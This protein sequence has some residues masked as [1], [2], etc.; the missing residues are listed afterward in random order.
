MCLAVLMVQLDT[1]V[2]NL[3]LRPIQINLHTGVTT[4][5]WVVDA[6][7]LV[8]ATFI[9][10]GAILG[11]RFGRKRLFL[12][13]VVLFG[14]GSV[15]SAVAGSAAILVLSRIITG[16]GAAIALPISLSIVSATYPDEKER[17]HAISIWSGINGVAIALG[18]SAGGIL[19]DHFGWRAIFLMFVPV[20][21]AAFV[22]TA[23]TVP[24]SKSKAAPSLDWPGQALAVLGLGLFTFGAIEG[25]AA[26]WNAAIVG[27]L[28]ASIAALAAFIAVER[29]VRR[30]LIQLDIF[31]SPQFAGAIIVALAMT[32]G[33][34]SFL[35]ITPDYLQT[36]TKFSALTAGLLLLPL[37]LLFAAMSP[38]IGRAMTAIGPR[39][40][41]V[42]GMALQGTGFL[43]TFGLGE[44]GP[45][46]LVIVQTMLLGL[47]LGCE[48]GPLMSVAMTSV[49]KD[50][51][52]M[53]SGIVNVARITGATLGVAVLGSIFA[54]HAGGT[55]I[56]V[57]N[58]L[59][60]MRIAMLVAST[61][62]FLAGLVA[63]F[64]LDRREEAGG[65]PAAEPRR[66]RRRSPPAKPSPVSD[67]RR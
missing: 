25:P 24:E 41:I 40:L 48:T 11:D 17:N 64:T 66:P 20:V 12:I 46:W 55:A 22:L 58:F 62:A 60:G 50:R 61:V 30:P 21:V 28:V 5:Q 51:F 10:T 3:A 32:F 43:M 34:Y 67:I 18:P 56:D 47:A 33:M 4:L 16:L 44:H 59:I 31:K 8:Y 52:G 7:N 15:L 27:A 57:P 37:G 13:G 6:Y 42:T 23:L 63:L 1:T 36:V 14:L 54:V 26:H 38:F 53:P 19:V 2:V 39:Q 9:L 35:F 45:V 65:T 29:R 49:P